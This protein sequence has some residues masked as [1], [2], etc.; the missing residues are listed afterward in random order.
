[1][2]GPDHFAH[3]WRFPSG[4]PCRTLDELARGCLAD[5]SE[6]RNALVR[7]DFV[8]FFQDN[9][10]NDLARLVPPAGAGRGNRAADVSRK[11]AVASEGDPVARR[12]PA[13]AAR[14]RTS[15]AARSAGWS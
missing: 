13:T 1:M 5:W 3:E 2:P 15:A 9:N 6:A 12:R 4:R 10:R 8:K 11:T 7:R 14:T